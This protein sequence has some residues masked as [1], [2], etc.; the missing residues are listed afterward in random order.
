MKYSIDYSSIEF[1]SLPFET[2]FS[3]LVFSE[4]AV[5]TLGDSENFLEVS[6]E[7]R[8]WQIFESRLL[9]SGTGSRRFAASAHAAAE[10]SH[11]GAQFLFENSLTSLNVAQGREFDQRT[12]CRQKRGLPRGN[13]GEG[14]PRREEE[15]GAVCVGEYVTEQSFEPRPLHG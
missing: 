9:I 7:G 1:R 11:S 6:S 5:G 2:L 13:P 12:T 14:V 4:S 3:R 10:L 15:F 8:S